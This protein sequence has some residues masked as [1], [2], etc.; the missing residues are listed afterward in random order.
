MKTSYPTRKALNSVISSS[1]NEEMLSSNETIKP[2][3]SRRRRLQTCGSFPF[4]SQLNPD[5]RSRLFLF[6]TPTGPV[7][8]CSAENS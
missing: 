3:C 7:I 6:T 4:L 1:L 2:G 5:H 8:L